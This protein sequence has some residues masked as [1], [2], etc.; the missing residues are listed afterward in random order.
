[1]G[2]YQASVD[3]HSLVLEADEGVQ[4]SSM[5]YSP[6]LSERQAITWSSEGRRRECRSEVWSYTP[7]Y[8]D[9]RSLD[10]QT[11]AGKIRIKKQP[12]Q[13]AG[14]AFCQRF[15]KYSHKTPKKLY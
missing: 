7:E 10:G 3:P 2:V 1:M 15:D 11:G 14:P 8:L 5:L 6:T 4:M 13:R 9:S 12:A